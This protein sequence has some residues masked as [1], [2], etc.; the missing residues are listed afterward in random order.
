MPGHT[1]VCGDDA[2]GLR[3]IDELNNAGVEVA[4]SQAPEDLEG[5][6]IATADAVIC[7]D[8]DDALN[9]EIALLARQ[10]NP[11]ARIVAR[12][13]NAVLREAMA[14]GNGPGAI[15]DVADLAA[16]SV[17]EALLKRTTHTI[18][19]AGVDF[20]VTG[21]TARRDGSLREIFGDLAPVAV[22]RGD[23]S[24]NPGEVIACP[25]RDVQVRA[26]DWTAMIGT[27]AEL[28]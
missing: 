18:S 21:A 24:E 28:A 14:D 25:G 6:G 9:L 10:A 1:I 12:L 20:V 26:G 19:V 16:P 15:L 3:I 23:D 4:I 22:I 7:A 5:A 8:D 11:T 13:S 2:L 27:A 17:V